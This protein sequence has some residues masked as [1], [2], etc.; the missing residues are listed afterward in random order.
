MGL[1]S[2]RM[3]VLYAERNKRVEIAT[4]SYS[5]TGDSLQHI[6]SVLVSKNHRNVQSECLVHEFFFPQVFLTILIMVIEQLC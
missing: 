6:Y 4:G 5:A 1:I 2:R 3:D